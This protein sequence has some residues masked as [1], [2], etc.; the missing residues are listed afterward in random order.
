MRIGAVGGEPRVV[1]QERFRGASC[2]ARRVAFGT[3]ALESLRRALRTP[4]G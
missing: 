2:C 4:N 1:Y 3:A